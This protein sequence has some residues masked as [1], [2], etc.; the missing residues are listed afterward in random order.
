M[1]KDY[2]AKIFKQ[3]C[4]EEIEQL[5][6]EI[7]NVRR[8][9]KATQQEIINEF[10]EAYIAQ[11]YMMEGGIDYARDIL[12]Q[13]IGQQRAYELIG[14]LTSSLKVR[15][16][17][18]ARKLDATQLL[19]MIQNE[20]PQTIAL[21]LSYLD[22]RQSGSVLSALPQEIQSDV[23]AKIARMG[24]TSPEYIKEVERILERKLSSVGVSDYTRVGGIQTSVDILNSVDRGTEKYI[25]ESLSEMNKE[26]VDEIK[27]RMF[28][29]EDIVNLNRV[30]IQRVLKDVAQPDLIMALK[31]VKNHVADFIFENMSK[32]LQEMIK[33]EMSLTG[34]VRLR[35]VEEAQQRIV[36][37]IRNLE[38]AGEVVILRGSEEA[39]IG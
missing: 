37:I 10:H 34:P 26:L 5:T 30:S 7:A 27:S 25:L 28:L 14:K 19:N 35:D 22:A 11:N 31:G 3:L 24:K 39:L 18:F 9:D 8:V 17:D 23:L 29:F 13:A 1:G 21:V 33:E 2:S 20:Q 12:N 38:E 36:T 6:L 16:F 32:R 4:E 15:P